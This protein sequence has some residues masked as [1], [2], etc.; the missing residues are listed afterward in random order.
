MWIVHIKTNIFLNITNTRQ[1]IYNMY[2]NGKM[3]TQSLLDLEMACHPS[4][5]TPNHALKV[6]HSNLQAIGKAH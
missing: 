1:T 6:I 3:L 4:N 5:K 2:L